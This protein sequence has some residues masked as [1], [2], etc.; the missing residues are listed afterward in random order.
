MDL[1]HLNKHQIVL[2]TLLVSF[3][4]SIATGIV[5]VSLM[6]QAPPS[7]SRTINQIVERTVETVSAPAANP[8][9][10]ATEHTVVVKEDDLTAQ[11]ISLVQK[12]MVRIVDA[13]D[14][15]TL[16]ARGIIVD[17]TGLALTDRTAV[18][19][20]G[21][22]TFLAILPGGELVDVM[23]PKDQATSTD[24]LVLSLAVGTTTGWA[25]ATIADPSKVKLG[26]SVI[27]IGGTG[28]DTVNTGVVASLPH[29]GLIEASVPSATPGSVL[30]N[31]FGEVVGIMTGDSIAQG[32]D[33]YSVPAMPAPSPT[34]VAPTKKSSS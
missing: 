29:G 22:K 8:A 23:I 28:A 17:K 16:V 12:A 1:E 10:V 24:T 33:Y 19:A 31:L 27:R 6:D 34:P 7:V 2:L 9:A 32:A 14:P 30:L 15:D 26:S 21:A 4:T 11:S 13:A 3:V 5:T 18:Y 20:S 25:P